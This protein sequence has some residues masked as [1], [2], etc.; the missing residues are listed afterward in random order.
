[1]NSEIKLS[2][3]ALAVLGLIA[4]GESY[5]YELLKKIK[6]RQMRNWTNIGQ[7]S[8]YGVIDKL[9]DMQLITIKTRTTEQNRTQRKLTITEKGIQL[10]KERVLSILT[11][12]RYMGRDWDLAFSNL[13]HDFISREEK[14][15]ALEKCV[16]TLLE[17][18]KALE[19]RMEFGKQIFGEHPPLQFR[20]LFQHAL[21]VIAANIEFCNEVIEELKQEKAG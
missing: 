14:I 6:E 5:P 7:S 2:H 9:K 8:I 12:D 10:L 19:S 4:E 17:N 20:G 3:V 11:H 21:K 16:Q 13:K 15:D 18:R 1:M